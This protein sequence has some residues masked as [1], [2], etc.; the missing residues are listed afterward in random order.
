MKKSSPNIDFAQKVG[1]KFIFGVSAGTRN[2]IS[3]FCK[4]VHQSK[5]Q[6]FSVVN[7]K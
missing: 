6:E 3:D 7:Q 4:L 2:G 5:I 1:W